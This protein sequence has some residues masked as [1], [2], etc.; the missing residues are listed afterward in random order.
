VSYFDDL[1]CRRSFGI[2]AAK[3]VRRAAPICERAELLRGGAFLIVTSD[4]VTGEALDRLSIRVAS[5]LTPVKGLLYW[6]L[7]YPWF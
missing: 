5:R 4:L 3:V 6:L 2:G 1:L 7:G